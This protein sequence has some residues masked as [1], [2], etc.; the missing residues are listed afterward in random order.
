M[1]SLAEVVEGVAVA[2]CYMCRPKGRSY[3]RT[4]WSAL[5]FGGLC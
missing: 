4:A 1:K 3:A 2:P 5:Q